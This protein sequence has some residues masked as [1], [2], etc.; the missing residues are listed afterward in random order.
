M[1]TSWNLKLRKS[2][3]V[4]KILIFIPQMYNNYC[5]LKYIHWDFWHCKPSL[6]LKKLIL[7]AELR[8]KIIFQPI[9]SLFKCLHVFHN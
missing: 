5:G 3:R 8:H 2:E 4:K 9:I 7:T 1:K 6:L